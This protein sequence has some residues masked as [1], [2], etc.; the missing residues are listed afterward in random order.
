[1]TTQT[2]TRTWDW[3]Y[4]RHED[5]CHSGPFSTREDAIAEGLD[6]FGEDEYGFS[7]CE[8]TNDPIALA[9]WA[10]FDTL[11]EDARETIVDNDRLSSEFDEGNDVFI[12]TKEQEGLLIDALKKTC[13]DWQKTHD[14]V[15]KANTFEASR[16]QEW[17]VGKI[18][19]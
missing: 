5:S 7:I 9:D 14:L 8:A 3:Y 1:M 13:H 15:F 4:A 17:I 12:C 10:R 16:N 6:D 18:G 2:D 11:I 19:A